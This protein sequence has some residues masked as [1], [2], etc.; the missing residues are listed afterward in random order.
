[1]FSK[2]KCLKSSTQSEKQIVKSH[3][4]CSSL[5][6]NSHWGTLHEDIRAMITTTLWLVQNHV[7][8]QADGTTVQDYAHCET[9][10]LVLALCH[11]LGLVLSPLLSL[12]HI[13]KTRTALETVQHIEQHCRP[14][15]TH[16][17]L[18]TGKIFL[19]SARMYKGSQDE[20]LRN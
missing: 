17:G 1:M 6:L 14:N 11:D 3:R 15:Q 4:R 9:T 16:I 20:Q 5:F 7:P 10:V 13:K 2:T 19:E 8:F 12:N 18:W